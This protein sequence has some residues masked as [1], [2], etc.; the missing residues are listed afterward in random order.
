MFVIIHKNSMPIIPG[1]KPGA[2]T[3]SVVSRKSVVSSVWRKRFQYFLWWKQ[4]FWFFSGSA[5]CYCFYNSFCKSYWV[6]FSSVFLWFWIILEVNISVALCA[7]LT[8]DEAIDLLKKCVEE[9]S[10]H[11]HILP[12]LISTIVLVSFLLYLCFFWCERQL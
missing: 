12:R 6:F 9:V 10:S 8:R 5:F 11:T 4:T 2:K 1:A 3:L 7:D